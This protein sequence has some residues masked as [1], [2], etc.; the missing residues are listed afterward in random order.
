ML[1]NEISEQNSNGYFNVD[2]VFTLD[3]THSSCI[4]GTKVIFSIMNFYLFLDVYLPTSDLLAH[5]SLTS[6]VSVIF[7]KITP[8]VT[9]VAR[10]IVNASN[11]ELQVCVW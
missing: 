4:C 6:I 1:I 9:E 5:C 8:T 3:S 11:K 7:C 10:G 2:F